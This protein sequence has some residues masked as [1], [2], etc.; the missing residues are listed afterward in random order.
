MASTAVKKGRVDERF[1]L[2]DTVTDDR[3][4]YAKLLSRLDETVGFRNTHESLNAE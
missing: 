1:K 4:R 3:P 2:L